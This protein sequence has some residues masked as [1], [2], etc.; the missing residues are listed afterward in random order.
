MSRDKEENHDISDEAAKS[1]AVRPETPAGVTLKVYF[2]ERLYPHLSA[3]LAA[4]ARER[5]EDPVIFV[6]EFLV[7]ASRKQ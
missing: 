7:N 5:P 2:D 4:C 1:E 3:A 6:G